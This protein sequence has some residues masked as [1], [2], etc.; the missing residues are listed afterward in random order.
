MLWEQ[1][2]MDTFPK[3]CSVNFK[4]AHEKGQGWHLVYFLNPW[5]LWVYFK[6]QRERSSVKKQRQR[7]EWVLES[8]TLLNHSGLFFLAND[9]VVINPASIPAAAAEPRKIPPAKNWEKVLKIKFKLKRF[10]QVGLGYFY[11][12]IQNS[13]HQ[14]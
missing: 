10:A 7:Y 14:G 9:N 4:K 5:V 2:A 1:K 11:N 8:Q 12:C 13:K 3:F 6:K